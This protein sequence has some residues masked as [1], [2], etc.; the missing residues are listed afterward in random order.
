MLYSEL[1]DYEVKIPIGEKIG[2]F[3]GLIVD[4]KCNINQIVV[5]PGIMKE[6]VTYDIKDVEEINEDEKEI[7]IKGNATHNSL[8]EHSIRTRMNTEDLIDKKVVS[9]DGEHVG[10]LYDFDITINK[11]IGKLLIGRGLKERRLRVSP[12]KIKEV[13]DEIILALNIDELQP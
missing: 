9:N 13:E 4:E 11:T 6:S 1:K 7:V 8:P 3:D 5:H 2:K 12:S 10:K